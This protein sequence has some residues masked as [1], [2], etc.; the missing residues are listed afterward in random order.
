MREY[1]C[2]REREVKGIAVSRGPGMRRALLKTEQV[3]GV[4][5]TN[6]SL[7]LRNS[8]S[9]W[10]VVLPPWSLVPL[11]FG[12]RC[13]RAPSTPCAT[14]GSVW[15]SRLALVWFW[16]RQS[17]SASQ[18]MSHSTFKVSPEFTVIFENPVK[19]SSDFYSP[20]MALQIR[21]VFIWSFLDRR[22]KIS[23]MV[24]ID[25]DSSWRKRSLLQGGTW[26]LGPFL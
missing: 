15:D 20:S 17:Q 6:P 16:N 3:S 14:Y 23:H 7:W 8:C 4:Y 12:K 22:K 25:G 5:V 2:Y 24:P 19:H 18:S 21:G 13:R 1:L 11:S 26:V 10:H 9:F